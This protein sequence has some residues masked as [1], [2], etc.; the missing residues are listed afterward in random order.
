MMVCE[1][2]LQARTEEGNQID[3]AD[4][5]P[6]GNTKIFERGL[7]L[8][9]RCRTAEA[10]QKKSERTGTANQAAKTEN[11]LCGT[12]RGRTK[13]QAVKPKEQ[14]IER[15]SDPCG[16]EKSQRKKK[17]KISRERNLTRTQA[18]L[19]EHYTHS[20]AHHVEHEGEA[21]IQAREGKISRENRSRG[22]QNEI[23]Q[24]IEENQ[25]GQALTNAMW[26]DNKRE[27]ESA[28]L[29]DEAKRQRPRGKIDSWQRKRI[30]SERKIE[31]LAPGRKSPDRRLQDKNRRTI[32]QIYR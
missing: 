16:K 24:E 3:R 28:R 15:D 25:S 1:L 31:A 6:G 14:G 10:E 29:T 27:N 22:A 8:G 12:S 18:S 23:C 2:S 20:H 7:S 5:R 21:K 13:K 11:G 4:A 32:A 30:D 9:A 17:E 19:Q 26:T